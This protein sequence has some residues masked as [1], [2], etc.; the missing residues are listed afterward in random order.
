MAS[1]TYY[2][3]KVWQ[4]SDFIP[5]KYP[6][7][8]WLSWPEYHR[9]TNCKLYITMC[10]FNC[11]PQKFTRQK[12]RVQSVNLLTGADNTQTGGAVWVLLLKTFFS[13]FPYEKH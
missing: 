3:F 11:S 13:Q 1:L 10:F 12:N 7:I 4:Y 9:F 8:N 6:F 2:W 5:K